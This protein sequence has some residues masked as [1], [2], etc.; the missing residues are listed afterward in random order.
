MRNQQR[1]GAIEMIAAMT[2]SGTIGAFV[3][4]THE[5]VFTIV[6]WRCVIGALTLLLVCWWMGL[7]RPGIITSRQV[8][9]AAIG[10]LALVAN[11]LLLFSAFP[12]TSISVATAVYNTQP[13]MLVALGAVV[14]KEKITRNQLGW[15]AIAFLGMLAVVEG[16]PP[17]GA[18]GSDYL[19]G[20]FMTLAGAFFYA[21][22]A[23]ITKRLKGVP[24]HLIALIQ[25]LIGI[26]A[27]APTTEFHA[28]SPEARQ[29]PFLVTLGIVH[30]GLMYILLYGAIQKLPT[31]LTGALSFV[32]P[33]VAIIVDSVAFG[34]RL[35]PVQL[36]G[37]A[38]ILL[39]AAGATLRW[40]ILPRRDK[41]VAP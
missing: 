23:I 5:S 41:P 19:I 30:T 36:L 15:L 32:Y 10:G 14:L 18:P 1:R 33:V 9:L 4:W 28:L 27:L 2:I 25:L 31:P 40:S 13:F 35:E 29:W 16:P 7:L 21:I 38:F 3:L 24:P 22:A 34:I 8:G 12:R 20:I 11:W 6:F 17:T 26:I 37:A 39:A